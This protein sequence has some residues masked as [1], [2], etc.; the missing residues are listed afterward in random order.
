MASL[1]DLTGLQ[2][3]YNKLNTKYNSTFA[4]KNEVQTAFN[5]LS[6]IY[7]P[8][9]GSL[10]N[11][12]SA[13][14]FKL[15]CGSD[16]GSFR[17][18]QPNTEENRYEIEVY[19]NGHYLTIPFPTSADATVLTTESF[20]KAAKANAV[21]SNNIRFTS[22]PIAQVAYLIQNSN[23]DST[24]SSAISAINGDGTFSEDIIEGMVFM[25]TDDFDTP[26]FA[27]LYVVTE[28]SAGSAEAVMRIGAP[29]T[30]TLYCLKN[31]ESV[32][33]TTSDGIYIYTG[34]A[35]TPIYTV[36]EQTV[37]DGG[38]YETATIDDING[39]FTNNN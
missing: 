34:S 22:D 32:G 19:A 31:L 21:Y 18:R 38:D 39:I 24:D 15:K 10:S 4:T 3:F 2:Q 8:I 13:S 12:F 36:L 29:S 26:S 9:N 16:F 28:A 5:G 27:V 25:V 20:N 37:I 11:A 35:W 6:S 33:N 1:I 30:N 17:F 23:F 14:S 7:A